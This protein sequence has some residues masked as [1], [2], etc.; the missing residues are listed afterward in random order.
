MDV[1][2]QIRR[3]A[4]EQ[5][6]SYADLLSWE[7]QM[8]G[9][10]KAVKRNTALPLQA[11]RQRGEI[12]SLGDRAPVPE[13]Q[14]SVSSAQGGSNSIK[15]MEY[16]KWDS[17]NVDRALEEIDYRPS[18]KPFKINKD[19]AEYEAVQTVDPTVLEEALVEKEKGN[20]YF[21]RSDFKKAIH[22][23]S[24][25]HKMNSADVAPVV[26]RA[27]AYI[28]LGRWKEAEADCSLCLQSQPKNVKAL[29]RRGIAR[30]Q[31]GKLQEAK[32]DLEMALVL[33]PKNASIKQEL[34]SLFSTN[35]ISFI[36]SNI[37][38]QFLL[39]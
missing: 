6:S 31:L 32:I 14:K 3:N 10:D 8:T 33:E 35:V 38:S 21:K 9:K 20:E 1:A 12:V 37:F 5:R 19:D 24:K 28:K 23:Y 7:K 18:D 4:E 39:N 22:C 2:M 16:R 13:G 26:N 25:S 30:K 17:F 34:D 11:V 15:S 29:W 36:S 27:V